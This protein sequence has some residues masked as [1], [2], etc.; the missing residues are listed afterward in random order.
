MQF[1]R[2]IFVCE[3]PKA[4]FGYNFFDPDKNLLQGRDRNSHTVDA[5]LREC[6]SILSEAIL[7]SDEVCQ[8]VLQCLVYTG[9]PGAGGYRPCTYRDLGN[10]EHLSEAA[11]Q[12]LRNAQ[13]A[14]SGRAEAIFCAADTTL[15]VQLSA[16]MDLPIV[17]SHPALHNYSQVIARFH[18]HMEEGAKDLP[19]GSAIVAHQREIC[20]LMCV[21][22]LRMSTVEIGN[23]L[24]GFWRVGS[25][26]FVTGYSEQ[27]G[28]TPES[29]VNVHESL[30]ACDVDLRAIIQVVRLLQDEHLRSKADN[31][32]EPSEPPDLDEGEAQRRDEDAALGDDAS[33][34]VPSQP[35]GE[36]K[37][38]DS[39]EGSAVGAMAGD[40]GPEDVDGDS[41]SDYVPTRRRRKAH[42]RRTAKAG[43]VFPAPRNSEENTPAA[44]KTADAENAVPSVPACTEAVQQDPAL[45]DDS[46]AGVVAGDD[47]ATDDGGDGAS[48]CEPSYRRHRPRRRTTKRARTTAAPG[49]AKPT[50]AEA[51]TQTSVSPDEDMAVHRAREDQSGSVPPK[52]CGG[53]AAPS[54]DDSEQT[55]TTGSKE[56]DCRE[57]K[58]RGSDAPA[59]PRITQDASVDSAQSQTR[60]CIHSGMTAVSAV[61]TTPEPA[62]PHKETGL[63][64]ESGALVAQ[65]QQAVRA[66]EGSTLGHTEQP[67][68][69]PVGPE[70]EQQPLRGRE[71]SP[72]SSE[73]PMGA[74]YDD[75]VDDDW[76]SLIDFRSTTA[77]TRD[78]D[79]HSLRA[80]GPA[81]ER[82]SQGGLSSCAD[83]FA[84]ENLHDCGGEPRQKLRTADRVS[85]EVTVDRSQ[86]T[87]HELVATLKTV[88]RELTLISHCDAR[89]DR[90]EDLV[91]Q[92]HHGYHYAPTLTDNSDTASSDDGSAAPT[93]ERCVDVLPVAPVSVAPNLLMESVLLPARG[94]RGEL[95][96]GSLVQLTYCGTAPSGALL[97]DSL[98]D[99]VTLQG[100]SELLHQHT[101]AAALL[102]MLCREYKFQVVL[103]RAEHAG[104][105]LA[106]R[107]WRKV[108][109]VDVTEPGGD[110]VVAALQEVLRTISLHDLL[111]M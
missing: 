48:N 50:T 89:S 36:D 64:A 69:A 83:W 49:T 78:G 43:S 31:P 53:T 62:L 61:Q 101:S 4:Q 13:T 72:A 75:V 65:Q 93:A 85:P 74:K 88:D 76:E 23:G 55:R 47:G 30:R 9:A 104:G 63:S 38:G 26:A 67:Q 108:L 56:A 54:S 24:L 29:E 95:V 7:Q 21:E 91:P 44:D 10:G 1:N 110:R 100:H 66:S 28:L 15:L 19:E 14:L 20:E 111:L 57:N 35:V 32:E 82:C 40:S 98:N 18:Q 107:L 70:G 12:H 68:P 11:V 8:R 106:F 5:C 109:F 42:R 105:P 81:R 46:A 87:T 77:R 92:G 96:G 102:T 22:Q 6:G 45:V 2:S 59:L 16:Q 97:Y 90:G 73:D 27:L 94:P 99:P 39:A 103:F 3:D 79:R 25:V 52:L 51:S 86:L 60:P 34:S 41:S 71:G 58:V 37:A 80:F 17:Y 33:V 84:D